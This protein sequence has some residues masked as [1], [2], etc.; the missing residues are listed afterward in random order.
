MCAQCAKANRECVPSSGITFRHQQ[1]PSMNGN[2]GDGSLKSFYGYKET[3]RKETTWVSIPKDLTFVHTS[4]PY[5]D[6]DGEDFGDTSL[7]SQHS[8]F[9]LGRR[10]T[11]FTVSQASYPA[12]ATHGLE[13]LSAVA[14]QDQYSYA[15]VPPTMTPQDPTP[16]SLAQATLSASPQSAAQNNG[17]QNLDFILNPSSHLSPAESNID[18]RLHIQSPTTATAGPSP[19]SP[20]HV[21]TQSFASSANNGR[22]R[23]AKGSSAPHSR[24][25]QQQ[26]WPAIRD[27]ELAFLLRDFSERPGLWMDIFDLN[28]FFAATVPALA[29]RCPLL[30][31]SCAALSSKSLARVEGRKPIM[32]GQISP[33]R[34]STIEVWPG[35][36]LDAEGWMRR[37]RE[38]YDLAVSLLRQTLAGA[39]RPLT[40]SLPEDSTP[41]TISLAQGAPLP[42][43]DSDE[44]LAA[45]AILCVYE[46][47]DGSGS[48]W[49]QHLD[50]AKT[51]FDIA[52]D[53]IGPLSQPPS[54]VSLA[55]RVT[56]HL[57]AQLDPGPLPLPR[58]PSQG[59][60]AVF[61]N[62]ARQDMLAAFISNGSTRLDT[63][64]LAMWR[65]AG[66]NLTHDG[67]ICPSNPEHLDYVPE[68][69]MA[70]DMISNALVW[71]IMKL[72]NFISAGDDYADPL[73]PLGLGVRQRSLLDY[74]ETL[75]SELRIW[76]DGLPNGFH[77]TAALDGVRDSEIGIEEKWFPRPMCASTMQSYHFARIQL[78]YNK[79]HLSTA[80][81]VL[82]PAAPGTS[83]ANRQ[84]SYATIIQQTRVHA[85]EIVAISLGR[86]DEGARIHAVQPLWTAG[87]VLGQETNP[88]LEEGAVSLETETWRRSIVELLRG[89][90]RDM[91]W[92]TS[93]RIQSLLELWELP[94]SWPEP[95]RDG[96]RTTPVIQGI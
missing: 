62:F 81:P 33:T 37:G 89:I 51:L 22:S 47:L 93:Y 2:D 18:P 7:L 82:G 66:L 35:P 95:V 14:S 77:A 34:Q 61:W 30:L 90:S 67:L 68:N 40:S 55:Q 38:Y 58:G 6:E 12:Y 91:G 83:L 72:V 16:T 3:F 74:W 76:Y 1:N 44:L 27:P 92:E 28:L 75:D 45:T 49:S 4:N 60:R 8:D 80:T 43:M 17:N 29:V 64:D 19:A 42:S 50:G 5:E 71:L 21:R 59:R 84:A 52:K 53:R 32:G 9:D 65:N 24:R 36:P 88:D 86:S 11:D 73:T 46:F 23:S 57:A 39:S 31:Y 25:R 20:L 26:Q 54:P 85:K 63:N 15:P 69:A 70:D 78:L 10:D 96:E 13:A 48:E 94:L 41:E 56:D 87:Q 79:P